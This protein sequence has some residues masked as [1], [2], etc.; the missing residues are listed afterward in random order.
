MGDL[1]EN[2]GLATFDCILREVEGVISIQNSSM[3]GMME[4]VLN[5]GYMILFHYVPNQLDSLTSIFRLYRRPR[6]SQPCKTTMP[7]TNYMSSTVILVLMHQAVVDEYFL[8]KLS[9]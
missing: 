9:F 1:V 3:L 6:A 8:Q 4:Y 7:Q 2:I 5:S